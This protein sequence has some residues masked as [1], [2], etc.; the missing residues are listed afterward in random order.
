MQRFT[1]NNI[2]IFRVSEIYCFD[3]I[4]KTNKKRTSDFEFSVLLGFSQVW[5]AVENN[6]R[7]RVKEIRN[8]LCT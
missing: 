6:L 3:S 2:V 5:K 7:I 4:A 8:V 1:S